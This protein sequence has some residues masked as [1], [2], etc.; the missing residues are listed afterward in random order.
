MHLNSEIFRERYGLWIDQVER[1]I[2][3]WNV[4][5][6]RIAPVAEKHGE[7]GAI[8]ARAAEVIA[9]TG[10]HAC[11]SLA[12]GANRSMIGQSATPSPTMLSSRRQ[13]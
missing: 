10:T 2:R 1:T 3:R 5:A 12:L 11:A 4:M 8:C 13:A 7:V 6:R 9:E